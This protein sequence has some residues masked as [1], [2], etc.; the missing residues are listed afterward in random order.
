MTNKKRIEFD[1]LGPKKI[2]KN[3]LWGAQTQRSL[4]NFKIGNEKI[5]KELIVALGQQKKAAA[6][7]N[8][9]LGILNK[10]IGIEQVIEKFGLPPEKVIQIQALTGD[11]VDNIPGAPGI[12]PKT[13]LQLIEEFGDLLFTIVNMGRHSKIDPEKALRNSNRK[14]ISRFKSMEKLASRQGKTFSELPLKDQDD[15]WTQ[16]KLQEGK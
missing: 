8:M 15:L 5:P 16:V 4:E 2:E 7:A 1:S 13:A 14:F 10:K 3:K 11:K 6:Q 12:G 9:Y